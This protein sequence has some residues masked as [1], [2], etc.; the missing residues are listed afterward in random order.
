MKKRL[1]AAAVSSL[2]FAGTAC[3]QMYVGA[4]VGAAKTDSSET[5]TRIYGG[6][7]FNPTW[8]VELGF[9]DLDRYRGADIE[10]WSLAGT[11]RMPLSGSLNL[12]GKV[13]ATS[14]RPKF[15][16]GSNHSDMLLGIGL[17]YSLT[18]NV[19]LRLEY[20]DFGRLS[21]S[22]TGNNS[23]GSNLGFSVNYT[24]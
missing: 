24:F 5:S 13:G 4:G 17:G 9:T 1:L 23:N 10:S 15:A 18:R 2:L 6:F 16:G 12:F 19:G 8:G 20:E 22:S 7:N 11:A 3:A 21:T 14:N